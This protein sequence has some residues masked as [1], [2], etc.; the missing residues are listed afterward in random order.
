MGNQQNRIYSPLRYPGGKAC[1]FPFMSNYFYENNLIG[2]DY[3]EPFAGGC[4]L[5]LRLLLEEYVGKIHI[6]DLDYSIYSFWRAV[7]QKPDELCSWISDVKVSVENWK[8]YRQIQSHLFDVEYLDVAKSTFFLNR[9]NVSG[10]VKGGV[11]GGMAQQ[12]KYKIDVRFN[13]RDL[14]S[15]IERIA[16][17]SSRINLTCLNGEE[18]IT[19][20]DKK[21]GRIFIYLDPP[22]YQKGANLYMNFFKYADHISLAKKILRLKS[23]WLVSYDN[24]DYVKSLYPGAPKVVY[25]LSQ[26]ASNRVGKEVLIFDDRLCYES[27]V[28]FL[29]NPELEY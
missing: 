22:Y 20:I 15:R 2:V 19:K 13:K 21:K 9:T 5:A 1:I 27:S 8:Y 26:C 14:I 23:P 17:F 18:F 3:A 11:I 28:N 12:G 25:H 24:E 4:G 16:G 6:N 10:I 29:N 7:L